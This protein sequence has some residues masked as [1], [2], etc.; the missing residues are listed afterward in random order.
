V[1]LQGGAN[2]AAVEEADENLPT[3]CHIL[4]QKG[5]VESIRQLA[6]YKADVNIKDRWQRSALHLATASGCVQALFEAQADLNLTD[7]H[8]RTPLHT[9][10]YEGRDQVVDMILMVTADYKKK[11]N[12][13]AEDIDRNT[14][15]HLAA[16]QGKAKVLE[17]LLRRRA[18]LP[19]AKNCDGVKPSDLAQKG[20]HTAALEILSAKSKGK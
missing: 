9:A 2:V 8:L 10:C 18:L 17:V 16:M 15:T 11:A 20:G 6:A 7:R 1:L 4:A 5:G 19:D 14:P 12:H 13:A 3:A